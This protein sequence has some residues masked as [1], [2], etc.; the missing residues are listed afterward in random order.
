MDTFFYDIL[1]SG[2]T[3]VIL[4]YLAFRLMK[5]KGTKRGNDEGG[6]QEMY[7][8]PKID[9]PPGVVWPKDLKSVP[10]EEILV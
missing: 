1:W 6:D 5:S 7:T 9:L 2:I 3:Y 8:P 4:T 10:D